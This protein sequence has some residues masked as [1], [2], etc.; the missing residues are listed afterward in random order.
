MLYQ[1]LLGIHIASGSAALFVGSAIAILKKGDQR[2][3]LL[4]RIFVWSMLGASI[5]GIAM[6]VM[7]PNLFLLL[8]GLFSGYMSWS[9]WRIL[10]AKPTQV[11]MQLAMPIA[12]IV[13]AIAMSVVATTTD[14]TMVVPLFFAAG[15]AL[16]GGTDIRVALRLRSGPLPRRL[17]I[18]RHLSL[19]GGALI[20][21][22][23][24]FL[25]VNITMPHQ[26]IL[27]IGPSVVGTIGLTLAGRKFA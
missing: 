20:A 12:L 9:G 4:G 17:V 18:S 21:A 24:A 8:V 1:G 5:S 3:R 15:M 11:V 13:V 27:W 7:K 14:E 26:W 16:I 2:H 23:T 22:W 25:V 6:S 10:R 19:M